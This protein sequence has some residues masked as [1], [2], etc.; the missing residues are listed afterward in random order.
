MKECW[1][2]SNPFSVSNEMMMCFFYFEF[3]YIVDY[4]DGFPYVELSMHA[5]DEAYLIMMDDLFD[6][7]LDSV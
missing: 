3:V 6:V 5:W 7:F 4:I 2:F 1:I